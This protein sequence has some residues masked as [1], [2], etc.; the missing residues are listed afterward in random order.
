MRQTSS[1]IVAAAAYLAA[2][3]S[4]AR[5]EQVTLQFLFPSSNNGLEAAVAQHADAAG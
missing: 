3:L 4:G 2:S 5:A 1:F